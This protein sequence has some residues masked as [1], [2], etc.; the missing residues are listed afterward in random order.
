MSEHPGS[1]VPA[2]QAGE[3]IDLDRQ[4]RR[5]LAGRGLPGAAYYT[6][7]LVMLAL[8]TPLG[9]QHPRLVMFFG[10]ALLLAGL[11]R[12]LLCQR[13]EKSHAASPRR[14][15]ALFLGNV[16]ISSGLFG[17]LTGWTLYEYG[18]QWTAWLALL[19]TAGVTASGI[20]ML[21]G[22]L[23]VFRSFIFAI[24]LPP[25]AAALAQGT[26]EGRTMA[27]MLLAYL[28]YLLI[29][30]AIQNRQYLELLRSRETL[31][32]HGR[33][34]ERARDR[35]DEANRAKSR[36]LANMS[37]EIRT[38]MNGILGMTRLAL[39]TED[40][41]EQREHLQL[42]LF[43]GEALL[44]TI[45]D[46]LDLSK[47]EAGKFELFY[48]EF[49]LRELLGN[50]LHTLAFRGNAKPV[51][52]ICDVSR[53][54][55][56]RL[57]GDPKRFR[58]IITN[59]VNNAVKFTENGEIIL[60][61]QVE[62]RTC[63]RLVLHCAVRD[64]GIG[65]PAEKQAAIFEAFTQADSTTSRRYGGTGLGLSICANLVQLMGGRIWVESVPGEGSTFHFTTVWHA[66]PDGGVDEPAPRLAG[67]VALVEDNPTARAALENML[68]AAGLTCRTYP[69]AQDFQVDLAN[70][71]AVA[72]ELD[73]LLL[74]VQLGR[75]S[76][77][78]LAGR[79]RDDPAWSRIP[80]VMLATP[81]EAQ[82]VSRA[83]LPNVRGRLT[84]PVIAPQLVELLANVLRAP[85]QEAQ[86]VH[87]DAADSQTSRSL[88]VLIAEDNVVSQKYLEVL[89]LKWGHQPL[90]VASG[91]EVLAQW[92]A[93]DVDMI[94]MDLQMPE[95]DGYEAAREIRDREAG[96]DR[97]VPI[98][99]LTASALAQDRERCL[100]AGM[101]AYL[102]K[103]VETEALRRLLDEAATRHDSPADTASPHKEPI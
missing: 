100:A 101:D 79:L 92:E 68:R 98:V 77:L 6:I 93:G 63:D 24:L 28:G 31:K 3:P 15:F 14:W 65:I 55:P 2:Q 1:P 82:S 60:S 13:F 11:H 43:S 53:E 27:I 41:E 86:A 94:L 57:L 44:D 99:A 48:E 50:T 7:S 74:D 80:V 16:I 71:P 87:A 29:A 32:R 21:A 85:A 56:D 81:P 96:H 88:R 22:S 23:V 64:T 17:I 90:L 84:K 51:E 78:E 95:L 67:R 54:V 47:I 33:E 38:P 18:V 66:A 69:G 52:L 58:Q 103:P 40:R 70:D 49:R 97:H 76:G 45:S 10:G 37:H 19:L 8:L 89:L 12:F 102:A 5:D 42:V 62:E 59:L 26:G 30:G 91:R 73:A 36:F 20:A 39:E 72:A 9:A 61:L 46:V 25:I 35:A 83:T 75:A 34:L 4:I